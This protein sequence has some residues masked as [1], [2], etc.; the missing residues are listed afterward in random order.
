[1]QQLTLYHSGDGECEMPEPTNCNRLSVDQISQLLPVMAGIVDKP[2]PVVSVYLHKSVTQSWPSELNKS[3]L[4]GT[5][6][7]QEKSSL[8]KCHSFRQNFHLSILIIN[9]AL[10]ILFPLNT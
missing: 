8:L 5:Q 2:S 3:I 7:L 4:F 9:L 6:Q 1:M 10:S